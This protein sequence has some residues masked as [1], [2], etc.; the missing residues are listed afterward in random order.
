MQ[1]EELDLD[2]VVSQESTS[3][4]D[5][6]KYKSDLFDFLHNQFTNEITISQPDKSRSID[7]VVVGTISL[8][9]APVLLEKLADL[10]I[11]WVELRKD[12][13]VTIKIPV[14]TKDIEITYNP[15][16]T[17]PE[18]LKSWINDAITALS[19]KE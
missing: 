6:Q 4:R 11:K 7:P 18:K 9:M 17:S 10:L 15:K 1:N 8:V 2:I 16:T 3:L 12:C 13:S 14:K 19:K 5:I